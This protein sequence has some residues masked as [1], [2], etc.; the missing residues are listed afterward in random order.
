MEKTVL[1]KTTSILVSVARWIF[2]ISVGYIALYPMFVM[3]SNSFMSM[4]DVL[5]QSVVY[6]PKTITFDNFKIVFEKLHFFNALKSTLLIPIISG[7]I[8]VVTCAITAYGFARFRFRENNILFGLVIATIAVPS[9]LLM[10]PQYTGFYNFD[11]LK[12]L[13]LFNKITGNNLQI[14]L[15][16][17]GFTMWLPSLFSVGLRSGVFIFIY[18]QFFKG[19]PKEFEEAAYVDGA[20][21][22]M[23]FVKVIVPSSTVPI[24]TVTVFS[25]VWHWNEYY[26]TNMFLAEENR[27]LSVMLKIV[28]GDTKLANGVRMAG[29][30]VFII[31]VLV[32]YLILQRKF[33][34][35]ID[36]VG[37]V[38]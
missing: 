17:T 6:I 34:K 16:N 32:I 4:D 3:I 1:K 7:L 18:R 14:N 11:P 27:P 37:I 13:A 2:L 9:T 10:I 23:A 19:L 31:P 21:P 25:L 36:K 30:L 28:A 29:A 5:D 35:S 33:I 20:N 22:F 12:I 24:I 8:E 15:L 26:M 38:G